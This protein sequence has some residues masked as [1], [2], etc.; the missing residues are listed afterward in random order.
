[1]NLLLRFRRGARRAPATGAATANRRAAAYALAA[2]GAVFI[3]RTSSLFS[4]LT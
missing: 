1:V 4:A 2:A 3:R